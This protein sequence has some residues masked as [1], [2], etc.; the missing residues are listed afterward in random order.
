[1]LPGASRHVPTNAS[2]GFPLRYWLLC[3]LPCVTLLASAAQ[4]QSSESDSTHSVDATATTGTTPDAILDTI[5]AIA[6]VPYR[7]G[8]V[9]SEESTASHSRIGAA[10]LQRS[11]NTLAGVLARESGVQHRQSGGF[12]SFSS[13]SIRAA[14][15]AQTDVYLDG[16]LLNSGGSPVVDLST[17]EVLNLE[18]ID[19]YR[20]STPLQL[21]HGSIG[22]AVNLN[23][24]QSRAEPTTR[25]RLGVGSLGSRELQLSH[26][27]VRGA[28]DMVA[29]ISHRQSD[30]DFGFLSDNGTPLNPNDDRRE[31]RHNADAR[32]T[33]AL[34]R[35]GYRQNRDSRTD[36][37]LQLSARDLG[38]PEFRNNPDNVA[39]YDTRGTQLQLS[40]VLDGLGQWNSRHDLYWHDSSSHY[41]DLLSQVGLGAQDAENDSDTLGAKTYWEYLADSGS[42][43]LSL[44]V[45]RERFASS[46]ARDDTAAFDVD[47]DRTQ[48]SIHYVWFDD[49]E[50]WSLTPAI[51]WQQDELRGK[52]PESSA[53]LP[54]R[55]RSSDTSL[56]IG[57]AY[58]PPGQVSLTANAGSYYREPSFGELFGSSGLVNGNP[59]LQ[60]E[61]GF[62]VDVG[63]HFRSQRSALSATVFGSD[64]DELIVTT[65]NS[66]GIGGPVNAGAARVIGLE[67]AM[68]L[69]ITPQLD[70]S[71]NLTW[72]SARNRDPA[73]GFHD[74]FL[75]GEAQ[76]AWSGKLQYQPSQF[77]FWYELDVLRKRFYDQAN[78]LPAADSELH[79][80]GI[81]WTNTQWQATLGIHNL[82][83]DNIEDFNG[84]PKPGRTWS[85]TLTRTLTSPTP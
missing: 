81:D 83:D 72:Q 41:R 82:G 57:L 42:L 46:D 51:R 85:L 34:L 59:D 62:N 53:D 12:G 19:I 37:T 63:L 79:S 15:G 26:Q 56:Q 54:S 2:P 73:A 35:T 27:T 49:S 40:Q 78:I 77:S 75:P 4:A 3:T 16:I 6:E 47:R 43:G 74:R 8:E 76:F 39:S 67:L 65:Y 80:I 31:K 55:R 71:S 20:G 9:I 1:M 25:V 5:R 68:D 70:L 50:T 44:D 10:T 64:R 58:R 66:R 22:G 45:R 28:W 14:T 84:F 30:N 13:I 18:S 23:T 17:L 69:A 38:V 32:R 52:S 11:N 36:L 33:T 61:E 21:G 60:P 24:L 29:A 7:T 48:A